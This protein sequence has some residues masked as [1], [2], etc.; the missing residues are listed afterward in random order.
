MASRVWLVSA[1]SYIHTRAVM[2][3]SLDARCAEVS[4]ITSRYGHAHLDEPVIGDT[5]VAA[6]KGLCKDV[7]PD[8][9]DEDWALAR[10]ALQPVATLVGSR[11]PTVE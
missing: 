4:A 2:M 3:P 6:R 11:L 7:F 9:L 1:V 5:I 10:E 8:D